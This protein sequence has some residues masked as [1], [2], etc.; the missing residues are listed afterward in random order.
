MDGIATVIFLLS[1]VAVLPAFL[2]SMYCS[3]VF[4]QHLKEEH[5]EVWREI[6]PD[7]AAEPSFSSPSSRFITQRK[8]RTLNDERLT[9]L[10][11]RCYLAVHLAV[12]V[13]MV[14]ILSALFSSL[15]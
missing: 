5:P 8:Y 13:F 7:P 10:G 14:F 9:S 4:D 11:D 12:S 15:S 6:A 2:M 3:Y 1:V